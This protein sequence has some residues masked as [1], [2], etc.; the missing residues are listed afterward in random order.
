MF[1]FS[2]ICIV[3]ICAWER[4]KILYIIV[5]DSVNLWILIEPKYAI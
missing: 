4:E 1:Y 3:D 2:V 5:T